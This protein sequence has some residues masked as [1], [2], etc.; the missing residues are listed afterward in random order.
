MTATTITV[1]IEGYSTSR[2][3]STLNIQLKSLSSAFNL[4][5]TVFSINVS[6]SAAL[7]YGSSSS[8]PYGGEF[9]I[10]V[11]FTTTLASTSTLPLA[12]NIAVSATISNSIGTSNSMSSQ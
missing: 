2:S 9:A 3:L 11:P 7:W 4:P 8:Q 6:Q 12:T 10:S 5:S 1:L